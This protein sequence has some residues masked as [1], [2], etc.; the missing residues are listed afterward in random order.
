VIN[1]VRRDLLVSR[2]SSSVG[3]H[4]PRSRSY[5][6]GSDLAGQVW[7]SSSRV[8]G[9][10]QARERD[11]CTDL[12]PSRGN[13][14]ERDD[15]ALRNAHEAA[16]GYWTAAHRRR[17]RPPRPAGR[18]RQAP[19]N[20]RVQPRLSAQRRPSTRARPRCGPSTEPP[21]RHISRAWRAREQPAQTGAAQTKLSSYLKAMPAGVGGGKLIRFAAARQGPAGQTNGEHRRSGKRGDGRSNDRRSMRSERI[22][23]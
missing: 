1:E 15:G 13:G 5:S 14:V 20:R 8:E 12:P 18:P 9:R 21:R 7:T 16:Q 3:F 23:P 6:P 10:K 4:H 17:G 11:Q 19:T 22:I 2:S